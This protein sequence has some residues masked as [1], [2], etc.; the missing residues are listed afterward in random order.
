MILLSVKNYHI[1]SS[2]MCILIINNNKDISIM[3][4]GGGLEKP[5]AFPLSPSSDASWGRKDEGIGATS[6]DVTHNRMNTTTLPETLGS[7]LDAKYRSPIRT[8]PAPVL[9]GRQKVPLSA[10]RYDMSEDDLFDNDDLDSGSDADDIIILNTG[11]YFCA[12]RDTNSFTIAY[13]MATRVS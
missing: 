8:V 11:I 10:V 9:A 5:Y 12:H 3:I 7:R 1:N 13:N 2:N 4:I 6:P